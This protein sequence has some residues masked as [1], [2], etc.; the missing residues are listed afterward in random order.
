MGR[1]AV[2]NLDFEALEMAARKQVLQLAAKAIEQRLHAD[3]S[4]EAGSRLPCR[5]GGEAQ[6]MGRRSKTFHS[7]LGPLRLRRAYYYC[8]PCGHGYF[9]RDLHLG[10]EKSS[11]SPAVTRMTGTV[12]ALVSFEEGRELLQELAGVTIDAKLV[13]RTAQAL[14]EEI[15]EDE[16]Q[17][18]E[19]V[20]MVPLP[21]TLYLGIDGT[22]I[23]MRAEELTG[24]P[25]KSTRLK[26]PGE[27]W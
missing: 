10:M 7:V 5:C 26:A 17:H 14:G 20:D 8:A 19:P 22:G 2:E 21:Q 1:Q 27:C 9:P 3:T 6:F 15:A 18:S 13:E 23:P 25:G 24:V 4:D 16:R 11:L 12:G